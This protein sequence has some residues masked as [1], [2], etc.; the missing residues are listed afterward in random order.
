MK[1][2]AGKMEASE[3]FD[4][5]VVATLKD[6][7]RMLSVPIPLRAAAPYVKEREVSDFA[8]IIIA[9]FIHVGKSLTERWK[10]ERGGAHTSTN[11]D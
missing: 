5:F 10:G 9:V 1:P 8:V 2:I 11:S 6:A 4:V 7:L 3:I